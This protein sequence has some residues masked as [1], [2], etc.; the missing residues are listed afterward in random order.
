MNATTGRRPARPKLVTLAAILALAFPA[1]AAATPAMA[2]ATLA[3]AAAPLP[4]LPENWPSPDLELGLTDYPG[5]AAELQAGVPLEFRYQYLCGGVNTGTGWATWN[6]GAKFADYYVDE[7]IAVGMTP[8]FPYY[9]MLQSKPGVDAFYAGTMSEPEADLSNLSNASTMKAYWADVRLLFQHLG[10]YTQTIVVN[11]EPDLWGYVQ[12]AS[13]GDKAATIPAA[14]AGSGD[15]DVAGLPDNAAGFAQAFVRLRDKYAPNVL[16]GY[17]MSAWGTMTDPIWQDTPLSEI[18]ALADR[19]A[20]FEASLGADFDLSFGD[21][22]DRDA[23]FDRIINGDGGH[24]WWD[25]TDYARWNRWIGRFVR[26]SGLRMVLWQIPLGNTKM[27]AVDN[28][29]G[30]YQDNHVEW[31]LGDGNAA[32]LQATMDAGVIALLYGGGADGT[33]SAADDMGDGLTNPA[34][35]NGNSLSSYSAD[36]DG[37]YFRHQASAYYAVGATALPGATTLPGATP[38]PGGDDPSSATAEA[39]LALVR[40]IVNLVSDFLF[41]PAA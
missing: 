2:A 15:P 8:V 41:D 35:I 5:G 18:D 30:H 32:N 24:S 40:F 39:V 11:V 27:R 3:M 9:Q 6:S 7:S 14:V 21:P 26:A 25:A 34:P 17:H 22:A 10:A 28:S 1:M 12:Q 29:W 19:S 31:W 23:D 13:R 33:T 4:P 37:G 20:A 36:D 38:L 16:L